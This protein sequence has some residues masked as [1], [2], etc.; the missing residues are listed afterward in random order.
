MEIMDRSHIRLRVFER[1]AGETLA[2]GT[3]ACAA[4]AV[5]VHNSLLDSP[6]E[7]RLKGGMLNIRW[8]GDDSSLF[9]TGPAQTVYEGKMTL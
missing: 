9:M 6:V 7:V 2:C 4:V 5:G 1:R 3:G 8:A